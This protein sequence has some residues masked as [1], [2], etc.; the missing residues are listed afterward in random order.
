MPLLHAKHVTNCCRVGGA[1]SAYTAKGVSLGIQAAVKHVLNRGSLVGVSVLI[2]GVGKVGYELLKRMVSLGAHVII[3]DSNTALMKKCAHEFSVKTV[4][5]CDIYQTDCDVFAPC[6][7][8]SVLT[9]KTLHCLKL[10][11]SQVLPIIHWLTRAGANSYIADCL[12]ADYVINAGGLIFSARQHLGS[13]RGFG[14]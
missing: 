11:L 6:A 1:P 14:C 12:C 9:M 10:K 5:P 3:S 4:D 8:G 2:Q 7:T 13:A